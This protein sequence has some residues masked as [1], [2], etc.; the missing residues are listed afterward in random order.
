MKTKLRRK[1][2]GR[3]WVGTTIGITDP[4]YEPNSIEECDFHT[5]QMQPGTYACMILAGKEWHEAWDT[6][7]AQWE[8][9]CWASMLYLDGFVP[10]TKARRQARQVGEI[11]VDAGTAGFFRTPCRNL[12]KLWYELDEARRKAKAHN[13]EFVLNETDFVTTTG[14]GDGSYPVYAY[15]DANGKI[16]GLEVRYINKGAY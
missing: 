4:F 13:W 9:R 7:P 14:Y 16:I 2:C 5:M 3:M 11:A 8:H 10:T 12:D 6:Q 1:L 15:Y